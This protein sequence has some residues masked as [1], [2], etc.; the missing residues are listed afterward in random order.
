MW[1]SC[2]IVPGSVQTWR[3]FRSTE[4]DNWQDHWQGIQ[5]SEFTI[6]RHGMTAAR[7][8]PGLYVV[9]TP[10]GNLQDI[11]L[12]ALETLAGCEL[13]AC[14][15]T[16]VTARLLARYG[17]ETPRRAYHEHNAEIAGPAIL[18][19]V[20]D[21]K[22]VALVSDAGTPLVSDPGQR[23]VAS[24]RSAGLPVFA[25]PGA[26]A[27]LAALAASGLPTDRFTF[28]GFLPPRQ[29][30]RRKALETFRE[31]HGTLVFFEGPSRLDAA[32]DDMA[33]VFG[34]NHR[35]CVA[36]E[37]TKMHEEFRSAPLAELAQHY[38][39]HPSRG[40]IVILVWPLEPASGPDPD[41]V[42]KNL[43]QTMSVSRA[44]AEAAKLTGRPR[45]ELYQRA[46]ELSEEGNEAR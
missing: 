42:L 27:P 44:A 23:L 38:R 4:Q 29:A 24:A 43:M 10:I 26:S 1:K 5:M 8:E 46:L 36:R 31:N 37:L 32:L 3:A 25:I 28:A 17:I 34:G 11:T 20:R 15:D 12:R 19:M 33:A 40:E 45:R 39:D 16:R 30:A 9:S 6:N 2:A 7:P 22:P 18:D 14:E 21:G 35:A 41:A 13:I